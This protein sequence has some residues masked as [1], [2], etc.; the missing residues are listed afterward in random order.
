MNIPEL[1]FRDHPMVWLYDKQNN[2]AILAGIIEISRCHYVSIATKEVQKTSVQAGSI[3]YFFKRIRK[4]YKDTLAELNIYNQEQGKDVATSDVE[5]VTIDLTISDY[6]E[7]VKQVFVDP[8]N[9]ENTRE[10]LGDS[11][12]NSKYLKSIL[13]D[14]FDEFQRILSLKYDKFQTKKQLIRPVSIERLDEIFFP[15]SQDNTVEN[16]NNG[17]SSPLVKQQRLY[18]LLGQKTQSMPQSQNIILEQRTNQEETTTIPEQPERT[19]VFQSWFQHPSYLFLQ[20]KSTY[21]DQLIKYAQ[22]LQAQQYAMLKHNSVQTYVKTENVSNS[23]EAHCFNESSSP[24]GGFVDS[25]VTV[26]PPTKWRKILAEIKPT[27]PES[28]VSS[29]IEDKN[30]INEHACTPLFSEVPEASQPPIL[31][32]ESSPQDDP[33]DFINSIFNFKNL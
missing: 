21:I 31:T 29:K 16:Y 9:I 17:Y 11:L 7:V 22:Y 28:V 1:K 24:Q 8:D 5:K 6:E 20:K 25:D 15:M 2:R 14:P 27:F 12:V 4:I 23:N 18:K 26:E 10:K 3:C 13:I 32:S 33:D 19:Y 30:T